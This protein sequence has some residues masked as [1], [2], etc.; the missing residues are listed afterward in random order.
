MAQAMWSTCHWGDGAEVGAR[1][2][3]DD[4]QGQGVDDGVREGAYEA[5][6]DGTDG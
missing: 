5:T 1:D 2:G 6:G 3:A 4:D